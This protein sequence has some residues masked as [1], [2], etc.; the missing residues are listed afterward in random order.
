MKMP[1]ITFNRANS[2][3]VKRGSINM[4]LYMTEEKGDLLIQVVAK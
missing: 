1:T 4:K 3:I 2:L